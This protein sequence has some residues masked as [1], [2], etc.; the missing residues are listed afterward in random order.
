MEYINGIHSFPKTVRQLF[1]FFTVC[2]GIGYFT[3]FKF[4][5]KTTDL[6]PQ[7]VE[8]NY[9]G[10]E[11]DPD[12]KV[13]KFKKP[14]GE[15]LTTIH[16]HILSFSLIFFC[17]GGI[18]LSVPLH[19]GLKGFLILEPFV[20]I[21]FTFGGIWLLWKGFVGLK[22]LVMLSGMLLTLS[23]V[24]SSGIIILNCLKKR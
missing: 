16:T 22:Y 7:G 9:I 19:S 23:F 15:I 3:G 5:H 17:L 13:M 6:K 21:V 24:L 18:L 14:E 12:A 20:S 11:S 4:I 10:N 8:E 2:L 1:L